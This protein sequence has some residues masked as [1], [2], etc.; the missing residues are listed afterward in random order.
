MTTSK[1]N[2]KNTGA[3]ECIVYGQE[4][5]GWI[6]LFKL[7]TCFLFFENIQKS[8]FLGKIDWS[9]NL[10]LRWGRIARDIK[11]KLFKFSKLDKKW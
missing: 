4:S 10:G 2:K 3:F 11:K 1:L 6:S 7:V 8:N 9:M 5:P